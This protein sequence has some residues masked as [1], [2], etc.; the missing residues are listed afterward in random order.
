M[1]KYAFNE[2]T[3][4][5]FIFIISGIAISYGFIE[6]PSVLYKK[7]GAGGWI[8]LILGTLVTMAANLAIVQLMKKMPD[9]TILD[10]L[11]KY[12]GKW[13]A[14][15]AAVACTAYFLYFAYLGLVYSTRII[16]AR[17]LQETPGFLIVFMLLVPTYVIARSGIRI[18]GRYAELSMWLSVWIPF[19]FL[20][21]WKHLHW[22]YLLP[23]LADG[24]RPVVAE[25]PSTFYYFLGFFSTAFLYPFL[26]KKEKAVLGVLCAHMITLLA[27]LF[28][29]IL[30][31]MFFSPHEMSTVNQLGIYM[32]KSVE[33][34]FL[35]QVEG[36]FI[37]LYLFI[38]SLSWIPT[39]Y[40]T[41]FCLSWL[42]G[43]A[44]HRPLM[45]ILLAGTVVFSYFYL[46]GFNTVYRL[47]DWQAKVG[48]GF[49][50]AA[51]VVLLGWVLLRDAIRNRG[52]RS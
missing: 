52:H 11:A 23:V 51:P 44:D 4:M 5:Q 19:I 40:L 7:A 32:L 38:F 37:V 47:S 8:T 46:P 3:T 15:V 33:L 6:I 26:I 21:V 50:Y 35:E 48:M 49:E 14:R 29:T 25:V 45:R 39:Y 2:I 13:T 42:T 20:L 22:L 34:P 41:A 24:W 43:R 9:G 27:Y 30:C 10:L 31:F 1:K 12:A 18:V 28:I 36:L 17:V 16:K